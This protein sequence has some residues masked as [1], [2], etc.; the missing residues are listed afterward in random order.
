MKKT[1]RA[2]LLLMGLLVTVSWM[3]VGCTEDAGVSK[4][5]EGNT[6]TETVESTETP[7]PADTEPQTEEETTDAVTEEETTEEVT[8]EAV[9]EPE[10]EPKAP[11][12]SDPAPKPMD[13]VP[14]T[15]EEILELLN[16]DVNMTEGIVTTKNSINGMLSETSV[17]SV[18]ETSL[19]Y[20]V[21][22][23]ES[24]QTMI[25]VDGVAYYS[26]EYAG[27]KQGYRIPLTEE[28]S[29][30]LGGRLIEESFGGGSNSEDSELNE[31]FLNCDWTGRRHSDGTEEVSAKLSTELIE[32]MLG[33]YMDGMEML[34]K[35][36]RS[37][38]GLIT[39][40]NYTMTMPAE[41]TG[42][43][44][45]VVNIVTAIEYTTPV[46][47][48][49]TDLSGY[50]EGSYDDFF[51]DGAEDAPDPEEAAFYGLDPEG[52]NYVIGLPSED[53]TAE[54]QYGFFLNYYYCYEDKSFILYGVLEECEE[55]FGYLLVDNVYYVVYMLEGMQ[56]PPVGSNVQMT[57]TFSIVEME[58]EGETYQEYYMVVS[59]VEVLLNGV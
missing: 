19:S 50:E 32:E 23:S 12:S 45:Y 40:M 27:M 20:V 39:E 14:M 17:L 22:D 31:A 3:L 1:M 35:V 36:T 13:S 7:A 29:A 56:M 43:M 25:I 37:A 49:P 18:G 46:I 5:T 52:D 6:L 41:L 47:Q 16:Q 57:A 33:Y 48:A 38:E 11:S 8:T 30:E 54:E 10:T 59:D 42:G 53:Y 51:G 15:R 4:D 21:Y 34:L 2:A 9:T 28:Q 58:Y 24:R 55:S 44:N 26:F